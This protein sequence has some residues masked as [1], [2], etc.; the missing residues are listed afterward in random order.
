MATP[1]QVLGAA[2]GTSALYYPGNLNQLSYFM[3]FHFVEY[4]RAVGARDAQY[5]PRESVY[6]PLPQRI[7][8]EFEIE[9]NTKSLGFWGNSWK[10]AAEVAQSIVAD[11]KG[12]WNR[13]K[14]GN[15]TGLNNN[16]A[17]TNLLRDT[18][19]FVG[20]YI[21]TIMP[22]LLSDSVFGDAPSAY[23]KIVRN[24]HVTAVFDGVHLREHA[25]EWMVSPRNAAESHT[26]EE[27]INTFRKN[28]H[29]TFSPG[30]GAFALDFPYQVFCNFVGTSYLY[31]VKR[32]VVRS[33]TVDNTAGGMPVFYA[34][35]APVQLKIS[36]VL[37][38][39]EILTRAD[40]TA[41]NTFTADGNYALPIYNA[42]QPTVNGQGPGGTVGGI[43]AGTGVQTG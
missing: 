35:G 14:D 21:T 40:F 37:Q 9:Y 28:M 11:G 2:G 30:L 41:D 31:P 36:M 10:D 27:I 34:G 33:F 22:D 12:V 17:G 4:Q 16:E 32:A 1:A 18:V 13:N 15:Y 7:A 3:S 5:L 42:G 38:E 19:G 20:K 29:P 23:F 26:L 6:L 43:N 39:V 8:E 25:F 24:P